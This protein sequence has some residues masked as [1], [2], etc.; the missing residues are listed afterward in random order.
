MII[1]KKRSYLNSLKYREIYGKWPDDCNE[2]PLL[3]GMLSFLT[4]VSF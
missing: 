1:I 2:Y 4:H 3:K